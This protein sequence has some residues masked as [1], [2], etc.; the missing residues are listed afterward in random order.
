M[1]KRGRA[2][3]IGFAILALVATPVPAQS[4]KAQALAPQ[5]DFASAA[6]DR[7]LETQLRAI[8]ANSGGRIGIYAADVDGPRAVTINAN[9]AFPMASTVKV[10]IAAAYLQGVDDGRLRLD[11]AYPLRI[12]TGQTGADGR[13]ITREGMSLSAQ[14]LIELMITKSD[15]QA[16]DAILSAVGGPAEVNRWLLGA[17]ISGLRVDRD[18]ATLL[19]DDQRKND[20]VLG[21]DKRDTVTPAAMVRLL[22]AL[23]R[24]EVLSP[25]S[26]AVLLGAMSRCKT[27]KTRIPALLPEG[28][29]IAHKTGTLWAQTSDVG[30]IRLPDG[31]NVALAVYVTGQSSHAAQAQTIAQ[32]ARTVYDSFTTSSYQPSYSARR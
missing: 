8:V 10:A 1:S 15:N 5:R 9:Q 19:R 30:I 25:Q 6:L 7:A 23:H 4:V 21:L 24:G 32:V 2:A 20:P 14:S 26:R 17:G 3:S 22:G 27:G 12:G 13:V 28:T 31:R 18:I 11:T 29:L 16:T